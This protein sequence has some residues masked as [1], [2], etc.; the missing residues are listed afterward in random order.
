MYAAI[1]SYMVRVYR[2]FDLRFDRYPRRWITAILAAAISANFFTHHWIWDA[3]WLLFA[4]VLATFGFTTMHA[5]IAR[6]RIQLPLLLVFVGVAL[7]IWLAENI[8]TWAR[9]WQYPSQADGWQVVSIAK[10]GSW[11]LLMII[12]VVL[13]A[14]LSPPRPPGAMDPGEVDSGE[15]HTGE[16]RRLVEG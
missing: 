3:R 13:V 1:G 14:W 8:G 10:L 5:R 4:A 12:S 15:M 7:F 9:A 6:A 11:F 2:L 16:R